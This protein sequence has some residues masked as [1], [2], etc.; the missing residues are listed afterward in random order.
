MTKS[1]RRS[2]IQA[3]YRRNIPGRDSIDHSCVW[4]C[5]PIRVVVE[6]KGEILIRLV[7]RNDEICYWARKA[8]TTGKWADHHA[9]A[10]TKWFRDMESEQDV[11]G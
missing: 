10:V 6:T 9:A 1:E 8:K 2:L 4:V 7:S 11:A 5:G 3:L